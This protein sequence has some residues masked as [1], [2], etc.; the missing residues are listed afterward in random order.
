MSSI[1]Q[2]LVPLLTEIA[3]NEATYSKGAY[4]IAMSM[5]PN[6]A[7]KT[8]EIQK[9]IDGLKS[10]LN[11]LKP[12]EKNPTLGKTTF[13][14][15]L[16]AQRI[17]SKLEEMISNLENT[18]LPNAPVII[19]ISSSEDVQAL[20]KKIEGITFSDT[21]SETAEKSLPQSNNPEEGVESAHNLIGTASKFD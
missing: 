2:R 15:T 8:S 13:K 4:K 1:S 6:P 19:R 12:F 18:I 7:D 11:C 14:L 21:I 9:L 20:S 10:R 16:E 5:L 17:I 3:N